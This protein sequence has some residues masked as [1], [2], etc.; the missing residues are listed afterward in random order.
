MKVMDGYQLETEQIL[1]TLLDQVEKPH[2]HHLF[3][4]RHRGWVMRYSIMHDPKEVSARVKQRLGTKSLSEAIRCR[5]AVF[6]ALEK[7]SAPVQK[8]I[9]RHNATKA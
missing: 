1:M 5:D 6:K 4:E 9:K 8:R 3:F 2:E 7:A